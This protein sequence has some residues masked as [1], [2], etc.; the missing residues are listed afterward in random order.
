MF[1]LQV[2]ETPD[3]PWMGVY[4]VTGSEKSIARAFARVAEMNEELGWHR[5]RLFPL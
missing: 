3:S 5:G 2:R 4:E 1:V